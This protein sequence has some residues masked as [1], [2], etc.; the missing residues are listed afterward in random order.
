MIIL[1]STS[2]IKKC[3][4]DCIVELEKCV[5]ILLKMLYNHFKPNFFTQKYYIILLSLAPTNIRKIYNL[6]YVRMYMHETKKYV[7]IITMILLRMHTC[8]FL[9]EVMTIIWT[10]NFEGNHNKGQTPQGQGKLGKGVAYIT[11]F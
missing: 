1:N 9:S 6:T 10:T 4:Y 3:H 2:F 11:S 7:Y 5:Y 8:I